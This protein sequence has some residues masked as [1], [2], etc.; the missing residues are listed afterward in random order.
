L[1]F[2]GVEIAFKRPDKYD[3]D[4]SKWADQKVLLPN[5]A[6]TFRN[7]EAG[8]HLDEWSD[9]TRN[10]LNLI[11]AR[12]DVPFLLW[13]KKSVKKASEAG[14]KATRPGAF[15]AAHPRAASAA[16][17][18]IAAKHFSKCNDF[19]T[20]LNRQVIDWSLS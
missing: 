5:S 13:G 3:P 6:L 12:S 1:P 7:G 17:T 8:S 19:L 4:L 20:S 16:N 9:F 2:V 11:G 10:V 14:I 15:V 18:L